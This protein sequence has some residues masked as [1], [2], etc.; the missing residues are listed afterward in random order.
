MSKLSFLTTQTTRR[1]LLEYSGKSA[2]G[3][4]L[5]STL[6]A[7][8]FTKKALA[9]EVNALNHSEYKHSACLVN[10]GSRCALRVRVDNGRIVQVEP[11]EPINDDVFG[12]HQIRPCLRGRSNKYRV[13]N[14]DRLKYPMKRIGK[15][16]EGKFKRISWDEATKMIASELDRIGTKYGNEAIYYQYA[17][18]AY[19]HTQGSSAWKRL[20]N[21]TG[22][23]LQYFNTYSNAQ[24][25]KA[26]PYTYGKYEGS[27]FWQVAH[28][29]LVVLFGL[30]VSETRMS[31][32]GQVEE[33]RRALEKSH[34]RVIIIDPRYTD[35]VVAEHAEWLPI[36]PSADA[37]LVAGLVHTML[38]ENLIKEEEVDKYAVGFT[39]RTLPASAAKNGSYQDYVLGNG[40][41][42]IEKTASWAS[43]ITGIP[44][45][46]IQQLAREI[47]SAKAAFICQGWGPQRH[48]NGEQTARAIQILPI[49]ANQFG[50]L[51]TNNGNWPEAV[52]YNVPYL[53]TGDN[54]VDIKIPLYS[55]TDAIAHPESIT[56]KTHDLQGAEKLNVGIKMIINQAGNVLANQHGD[57]IR[58]RRILEDDTQCET[59]VVIDN[60]MTATAKF[61]D[62]L[63]P[64]TTYLEA[65]DLVGNSYASGSNQY[66]ISMENTIT[67]LWECRS[68]YDICADIAEHLGVKQAF[69]EG[70][71]QAD[72]MEYNYN[73]VRKERPHLPPFKEVRGT[74]IIDQFR[75]PE[76]DKPVM[77]DFYRDPAAHPLTT[78]S[79]KVEIYS[80]ALQ[81]L[82][83]TWILPK[84]DRIPAIPEF[85][86]V[87]DTPWDKSLA[88]KYPLQL[89]GFHTKGHT[90]STY[91]SVAILKEAVPNQVWLNP[92]DAQERGIG[93]NDLVK[94]YNDRGT[95]MIE[96]KVTHRILPGVAAMPEGAWSVV[97][98]GI[99]IGGCI[100][101]ITS[102]RLSPLAKGNPQ[103]TNM[104]EIEK[105]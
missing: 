75:S 48:G 58:T 43:D 67:P 70:R 73:I 19:Y 28:S 62:I 54:A 5:F 24:I 1:Q 46:R 55:W 45:V 79:G 8:P 69:T 61:A 86:M 101:S 3:A 100:N 27:M 7:L 87:P 98:N 38:V 35:S 49:I 103:H 94:I 96:A 64:E 2:I 23:Y 85:L 10:C 22:G 12:E 18:G 56:D 93:N 29:D 21:L 78:P 90:H 14:P 39:Q 105:A 25:V 97:K 20:L 60:H 40:D 68:T 63:L 13:Y 16:G 81:N 41:D 26:T 57:L 77:A 17:T 50:R 65:S 30:N 51:G 74:G 34:A 15:R 33:M 4:A 102:H 95:V 91:A 104:V 31:G 47:C 66:M 6:S 59:I 76:A 84:G 83:D 32:G 82:Q 92:L 37:A 52:A 89:T 72:W 53:P 99:D 11:E 71:T 88:K 42:G 9:K 36:R 44:T 80:A